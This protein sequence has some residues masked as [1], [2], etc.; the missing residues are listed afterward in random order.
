MP[1]PQQPPRKHHYLPAFFIERWASADDQMVWSYT[2]PHQKV[3][4]KRKH[5]TATGFAPDLYSL[6]AGTPAE[7]QAIESGFMQKLDSRGAAALK[8]VLAAAGK[9]REAAVAS[10]WVRLASSLIS[11]SPNR[12]AE[13]GGFARA[14]DHAADDA[15]RERYASMRGPDW[16]ATFEDYIAD[17]RDRRFDED[18][19]KVVVTRLANSSRI[20]QAI[21]DM[22]WG[23]RILGPSAPTLLLSDEPVSYSRLEHEDGV[24]VMPMGPREA[25]IATKDPSFVG[26]LLQVSEVQFVKTTNRKTVDRAM[27]VVVSSDRSHDALIKARFKPSGSGGA[28]TA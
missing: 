23:V 24:L 18:I 10:D 27:S 20:G 14:R 17:H 16:P 21:M 25:F 4:I 8:A 12:V 22:T 3:D 11:R 7:Q 19:G 13:I 9:P 1:K 2:V 28:Q 6:S 26:N 5:S 15:T